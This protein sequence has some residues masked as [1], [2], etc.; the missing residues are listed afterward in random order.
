MSHSQFNMFCMSKEVTRNI[1]P[2][3]LTFGKIF[4]KISF[5]NWE[6]SHIVPADTDP[7]LL[8]V[9]K[10]KLFERHE[11]TVFLLLVIWF[12]SY[13]ILVYAILKVGVLVRC[14][15]QLINR[16]ICIFWFTN[17][18]ATFR[19]FFQLILLIN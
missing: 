12:L 3:P 16:R 2:S 10:T 8:P 6:S 14:S 4:P 7:Q 17:H 15:T 11:I 1:T 5:S 18:F 13:V 9:T 19:Y